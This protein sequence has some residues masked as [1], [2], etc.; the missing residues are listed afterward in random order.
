MLASV[1]GGSRG[2]REKP[3]A[4]FDACPSPPLT[5]TNLTT[6]SV[7]DCARAG[8]PSEFVA[9]PLTGATAPVTLAGALVQQTAENLAGLVIAQLSCAGA[10]VILGG[11]PS[12]F[13]MRTGTPPMGAIETMM[14]DCGYTQ[15]GKRLG[16]PT[17]AY[18]GLSDAKLLDPQA[19]LESGM[20]AI[21]AALAGVNVVSGPGMMDFEATQ[22]LEKLLIDNE[23]CGMALRMI[24]GIA[25]REQPLALHLFQDMG[26]HPDFLTHPHTLQW[27]RK[28]HRF[29]RLLERGTYQQWEA[30]GKLSLG[31]R[32]N[33][34][35]ERILAGEGTPVSPGEER[36]ELASI[37]LSHLKQ[38]GGDRLPA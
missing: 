8:I 9:M 13:D 11:S 36:Q 7:I 24:E 27:L 28:E 1:R 14:I 26:A 23:I 19:G 22:S 4:I 38:Q 12:G 10:P 21:L 5:W 17:H 35:A 29:P 30:A 15:I 34:E 6:Q 3:L 20:G 2:L 16:L 32:A 25:P 33:K 18:M 37:M 31:D